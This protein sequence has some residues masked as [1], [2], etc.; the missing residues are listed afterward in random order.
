MLYE[1]H[2]DLWPFRMF[3][4]SGSGVASPADPAFALLHRLEA[5][6]Q[7]HVNEADVT[8]KGFA[9]GALVASFL[10]VLIW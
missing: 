5:Q 3:N 6:L 9:L 7:L 2:R 8:F 4:L 1:R 10:A